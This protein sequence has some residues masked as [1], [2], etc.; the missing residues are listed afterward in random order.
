LLDNSPSN[1]SSPLSDVEDKDAYGEDVDL[2]MRDHSY[3]HGT[4]K[5]NGAADDEDLDAASDSD[6]S[7]LSEVDINDSEAET[8][9]L[10][11]TPPKN[12]ATRDI[13]NP[14]GDIGHRQ[15]TDR[16]DR[17]FERSPSKLHQ[18][19]QADV[20][21]EDATSDRNSASEGEE[22]DDDDISLASSEPD[23][24]A[25]KERQLRSPTL[26]KKSQAIP[27]TDTT[28]SQL[29]RKDSAESR[30]RKRSL[31]AEISESEQPL[32]KRTGSIDPA[33]RDFSTDDMAMVDDEGV[34]TNPQ[35]GNHTAEEDDNEELVDTTEAKEELPDQVEEDVAVPSRPKKGRRSPT[36][37]RK[38][39][40]PEEADAQDEAPDEPPEDADVQS[41][42]VPTPHADDDHVDGVDEEAEAAH[43]NEEECT[44]A[45]PLK[46]FP[47]RSMVTN[48]T[49]VE[50]KKAAWDELL[51]IEK[52]FSSFR[53]R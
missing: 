45:I 17:V 48:W 30:K 37:K 25:V 5:R 21:A 36:K 43:R 47:L 32:K 52:Q 28:T 46:S 53:E 51:A 34:L 14:A 16:R 27:S 39:K 7:K 49:T 20:D 11:N 18:Q 50:R 23:L 8:E 2:D 6:E 42:E 10:Y 44:K 13:V 41:I 3:Y 24:D 9:R 22:E 38:S 40:S 33:D 26:A 31:L 35:S 4:P 29:V 15:F 1:L 12:G 19:L